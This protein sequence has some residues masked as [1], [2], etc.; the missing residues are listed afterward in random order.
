MAAVASPWGKLG[1]EVAE[2]NHPEKI[3]R[4]TA[5]GLHQLRQHGDLS[6]TDRTGRTRP[7]RSGYYES[8]LAH[9]A[10]IRLRRQPGA[11]PYAERDRIRALG[12]G[13]RK[14]RIVCLHRN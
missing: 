10:Q 1:V 8:S 9:Y 4:L 3:W 5:P 6:R 13:Q 12:M 2:G 11:E 7:C 14:N